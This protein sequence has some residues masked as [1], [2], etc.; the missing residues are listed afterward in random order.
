M[1]LIDKIKKLFKLS[2]QCSTCKYW[3]HLCDRAGFCVRDYPST[4]ISTIM[5]CEITDCEYVCS[6][7]ERK[8]KK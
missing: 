8:E 7:Y 6:L 5:D 1:R 3:V 2:D 4:P